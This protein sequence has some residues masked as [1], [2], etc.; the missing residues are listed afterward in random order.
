LD[1]RDEFARDIVE[2]FVD[3]YL[4]GRTPSPCATCNQRIKIPALVRAA[5]LM[6]A[7][8][9][10][11]GHYARVVEHP[12]GLRIARGVD[13]TKDQSYFLCALEQDVLC[14]LRLPL[15]SDTKEAVRAEAL[16]RGLV[17]A[18]KGES[19]DLCFV[20]DSGYAAFVQQRAGDRVRPGW[21]VDGRGKQL[22]RHEGVH[23]FTL[24]QRKGL[25]I[26]AGH[27]VYVSRIDPA[28]GTVVVDEEAA[29]LVEHVAVADPV[30]AAGVVLPMHADVQ[31][32]YRHKGVPA[33]LSRNDRG[34]LLVA[35]EQP[36]RAPSSGQ[37]AVAYV[38]DEVVA[39]GIITSVATRR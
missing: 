19:Q 7:E 10:A 1:R 17:G 18:H 38:N 8:A 9:V 26:A 13:A 27:P 30:L 33:T 37:F 21:I 36:V 28:S 23:R 25:G 34:E 6:G 24:G 39:G 16:T 31:V 14:R 35:F 5:R 20:Q 4:T 32:R 22:G 3:A 11:T 12:D 15:G 2:P 29:I